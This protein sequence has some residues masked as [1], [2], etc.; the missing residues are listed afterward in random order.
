MI[1]TPGV[2]FL[3]TAIP[4]AI[5]PPLIVHLSL[6]Y[7]SHFYSHSLV[8]LVWIFTLPTFWY[9]QATYTHFQR[10]RDARR[11][12]AKLVPLVSGESFVFT[13]SCIQLIALLGKWP[14]NIDLL[15]TNFFGRDLYLGDGF[16][17][18]IETHG[19]T[20]S[21]SVLGDYR[22]LTANPENMKLVLSTD[23]V[24]FEKVCVLLLS[25]FIFDS[26]FR[27]QNLMRTFPSRAV[28][29]VI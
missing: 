4:T 24:H 29:K 25:V 26:P 1:F 2:Y 8:A 22:I 28:D 5:A 21:N 19:T 20:F 6:L 18:A 27:V 23:F 9:L 17:K 16:T 13:G 11:L 3:C 10:V 12:G 7:L 14:G 15:W